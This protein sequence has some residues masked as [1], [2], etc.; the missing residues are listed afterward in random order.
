MKNRVMLSML[1]PLQ[2]VLFFFH[3]RY[4]R[5]KMYVNETT[6]SLLDCIKIKP[7]CFRVRV[8]L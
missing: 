6:L 2:A 7:K 3:R 1:H 5:F 4:L 8:L